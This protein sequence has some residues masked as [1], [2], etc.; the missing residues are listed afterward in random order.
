MNPGKVKDG[1]IWVADLGKE[2][3]WS[4][5]RWVEVLHAKDF[6][7][8]DNFLLRLAKEKPECFMGFYEDIDPNTENRGVTSA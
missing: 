7:H 1:S 8:P 6:S 4:K 3:T 5:F 2:F